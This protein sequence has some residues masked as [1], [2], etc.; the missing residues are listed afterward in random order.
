MLPKTLTP[1]QAEQMLVKIDPS[2]VAPLPAQP[3]AAGKYTLQNV[4]GW[5]RGGWGHRGF[6][7]GGW[8]LGGRGYGLGRFGAADFG[9]GPLDGFGAYGYGALA[10]GYRIGAGYAASFG[11]M[12]GSLGFLPYGNLRFPYA[13]NAGVVSPYVV[14]QQTIPFFVQ[15][16]TVAVPQVT[17]VAQE[18]AVPRTVIVDQPIVENRAITVPRTVMVPQ[19]I[20]EPATVQVQSSIPVPTT[21]MDRQTVLVPH[22][23]TTAVQSTSIVGPTGAGMVP[24]TYDATGLGIVP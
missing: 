18:I 2:Q 1:A 4:H 14:D 12:V 19:T 20:L 17:Q 8:G 24:L 21:V 11:N 16:T 23:E 6:G 3:P 10:D 13:M 5:G 22:V 7:L 15:K 9:I